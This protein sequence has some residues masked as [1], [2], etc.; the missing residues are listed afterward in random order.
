[1]IIQVLYNST[2]F[3]APLLDIDA[4]VLGP[5]RMIVIAALIILFIV[6]LPKGIVPE[7]RRRYGP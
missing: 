3:L 5:L 7:R 4:Q 1:V 2:R 6:Y